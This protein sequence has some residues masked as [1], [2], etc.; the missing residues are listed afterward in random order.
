MM[1]TLLATAALA[2]C[3]LSHVPAHAQGQPAQFCRRAGT[4]DT[5]RPIPP[6][7]V[8]PAQKLFGLSMPADM[9]QRTTVFRCMRGQVLMCNLGANLP[10]GK[11]NAS[12]TNQGASSWCKSNPNS[13]F[14]PAFA[15]GHDTIY[16]WRC[17]DGQA[18]IVSQQDQLDERGFITRYWKRLH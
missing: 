2:L 6:A 8:T 4:D 17:K 15:A 1:R 3:A 9:V 14:I 13:D 11:A 12:R 7:L 18:E 10:C 16:N 5:Q